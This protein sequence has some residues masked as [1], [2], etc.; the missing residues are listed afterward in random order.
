MLAHST[1]EQDAKVIKKFLDNMP[2]TKKAAMELFVSAGIFTRNGEII[3]T[4][5]MT[6]VQMKKEEKFCKATPIK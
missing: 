2:K 4:S 5:G 6:K 3:P 1:L